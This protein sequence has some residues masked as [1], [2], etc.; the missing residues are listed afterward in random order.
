MTPFVNVRKNL[1]ITNLLSKIS[2]C[3]VNLVYRFRQESYSD[4]V[5][6]KVKLVIGDDSLKYFLMPVS[7]IIA[8]PALYTIPV[9]T[10]NGSS[11]TVLSGCFWPAISQTKLSLL[12]RQ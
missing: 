5:H 2:M 12:F 9:R 8:L 3:N 11:A 4:R 1:Y 10:F 7:N 6:P